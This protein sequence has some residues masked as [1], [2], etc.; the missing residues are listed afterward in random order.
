MRICHW[1]I[2]LLSARISSLAFR[3]AISFV[4]NDERE[5]AMCWSRNRKVSVRFA[6]IQR[7]DTDMERRRSQ[8]QRLKQQRQR[9]CT[10]Q[11]DLTDEFPVRDEEIHRSLTDISSSTEQ[12]SY[13]SVSQLIN[14][15]EAR[16]QDLLLV[17]SDAP[18]RKGESNRSHM[19]LGTMKIKGNH[20]D[21]DSVNN[22]VCVPISPV[23][24]GDD[25]RRG[26]LGIDKEQ[27]TRKQ[28]PNQTV[29]N[30]RQQHRTPMLTRASTSTPLGKRRQITFRELM[31]KEAQLNDALA[32][33]FA[34]SNDIA[35]PSP[36][37]TPQNDTIA[38]NIDMLNNLLETLNWDQP[39]LT[40]EQPTQ[41]NRPSSSPEKHDDNP[42]KPIN[43]FW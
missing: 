25:S 8:Q 4:F 24:I 38:A 28:A 39:E 23:S 20:N 41:E 34:V 12:L 32:D 22:T 26:T 14:T 37:A 33:L 40:N 6:N 19:S 31:T 35:P 1:S 29:N 11:Q 7:A 5:K 17:A 9:L 42:L 16:T 18:P 27:T 15:F 3:F 21:S 30:N 13:R 43:M 2:D 36:V 10:S